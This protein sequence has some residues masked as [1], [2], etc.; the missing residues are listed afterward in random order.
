MTRKFCIRCGKDKAISEYYVHATMADGH[1]S[2]CKTCV[3]ARVN[4]RRADKI[5]DVRE[6]DRQ[7]GLLPDRKAKV[8]ANAW[9]YPSS[10]GTEKRLK[11][12]EQSAARDALNH[13][14]RDGRVIKDDECER[15][16]A[17][18]RLDAHHEDYSK[19]LE[20]VW[21]CKEC[22]GARHREINEER[23]QQRRAA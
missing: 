8:R 14:V 15:C 6:Y 20:V 1:L 3:K 11:Y 2:V 9:R 21:L 19:P 23:R 17:D 16:G 7:R 4:K 5:E 22:H 13:A 12:P 10:S 18:W